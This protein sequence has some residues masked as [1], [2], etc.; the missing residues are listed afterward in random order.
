VDPDVFITIAFACWVALSGIGGAVM[1]WYAGS[2]RA[3]PRDEEAAAQE[4]RASLTPAG[5]TTEISGH[6]PIPPPTAV[7]DAD[8]KQQSREEHHAHGR[9]IN[10]A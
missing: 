10:R 6:R 8:G 4:P 5:R 9:R 1:V 7:G 2:K 3:A